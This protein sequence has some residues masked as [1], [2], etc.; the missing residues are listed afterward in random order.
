[1]LQVKT[2]VE[3]NDMTAGD[4]FNEWMESEGF[5]QYGIRDGKIL[6]FEENRR[7]EKEEILK[8]RQSL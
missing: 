5:S 3:N 7:K 4:Q 2:F 6:E 8:E 1:M